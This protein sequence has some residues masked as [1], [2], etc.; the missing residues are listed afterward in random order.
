[1]DPCKIKYFHYKVHVRYVQYVWNYN[2]SSGQSF[3][4]SC[5]A[6]DW[7]SSLF[8]F[9]FSLF[10]FLFGSALK[11]I[12]HALEYLIYFHMPCHP[13]GAI[14]TTYTFILYHFVWEDP[15]ISLQLEERMNVM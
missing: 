13:K 8:S 10:S 4:V 3:P 15:Q 9:H 2:E 6:S 7:T 12:I 11:E 1:M 5:N 14:H